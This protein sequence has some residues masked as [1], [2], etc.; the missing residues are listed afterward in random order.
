VRL[1]VASGVTLAVVVSFG[2][3]VVVGK[4]VLSQDQPLASAPTNAIMGPVGLDNP[5]ADPEAVLSTDPSVTAPAPPVVPILPTTGRNE[6]VIPT[7][8][9]LVNGEGPRAE[10]DA[11]MAAGSPFP[12]C[13]IKVTQATAI[14]SWMA[15]DRV[16]IMATGND[17]A[18]G[19]VRVTL[20]TIEGRALYT[21][22]APARD[23]G[24]PATASPDQIRDR[25]TTL[26]PANAVKS[27]AYPAWAE[28]SES[29]TRSEFTRETYEAIRQ[30]DAPVICLKLP[31]S[32]QRCVAQDP[33]SGQF[34]VFARG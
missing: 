18:S 19:S 9:P 29:P 25:L 22:Q 6:V 30:A 11:A 17:C 26:L 5:L 16:T 4:F 24:I 13:D 2:L 23:F 20:E 33:K 1:I 3:G 14:R 12:Q 10:S 8:G 31:T 21:L 7:P 34:R 15:P 27:S 32:A 28:G